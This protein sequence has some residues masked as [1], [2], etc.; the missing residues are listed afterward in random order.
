VCAATA[1][2]ELTVAM[3]RYPLT[4]LS[5]S[6]N[7]H[8]VP[9]FP[10]SPPCPSHLHFPQ[11]LDRLH[12]NLQFVT[13]TC[14]CI[15]DSLCSC[16]C[17]RPSVYS[18]H[19]VFDRNT[20]QQQVYTV[21]VA[22]AVRCFIDG[23]GS[24]V[25]ARGTQFAGKSHTLFAVGEYCQSGCSVRAVTDVLSAMKQ[26]SC[27]SMQLYVSCLSIDSRGCVDLLKPNDGERVASAPLAAR[28]YSAQRITRV[29]DFMLILQRMARRSS[30]APH[31]TMVL[32]KI[33]SNSSSS[34][35]GSNSQ[36]LIFLE[37][38]SEFS[39]SAHNRCC[40]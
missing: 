1:P 13:Y 21:S 31:H 14:S 26:S 39:G 20:S 18:F 28:A 34:T 12:L 2:T 8:S 17:P 38:A 22:P 5:S 4:F 33:C 36:F 25:V 11:A 15:G 30:S 23:G 7:F 24:C 6:P 29:S 3:C 16:S 37:T 9:F 32:L 19:R 35:K 10:E 27:S 40:H